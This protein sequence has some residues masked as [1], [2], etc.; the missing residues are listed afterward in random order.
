[1]STA[2][3]SGATNAFN[4]L[5][6]SSQSASAAVKQQMANNVSNGVSAGTTASGLAGNF[7]TFL[8]ILT[9]QLQHQDPTAP[10]DTNQFTQEL[11]QFSGV[12]Q[13]LNT[14]NLLQ[15]LVDANGASGVKS[16]L[17]YVGQYVQ[18]SASNQILVQNG[19]SEFSYTLP[20]VAQ[21]VLL[22]V[23]NA[24]GA[25]VANFSGPAANGTDYVAW[26]GQDNNGDQL[27]DGIYTIAV[28]ATDSGGNN[29]TAGNVQ[30]IGQ[31]TGV[32]TADS[33]GNDLMLGPNLTINDANVSAVFS[34]SA[35][36][37]ATTPSS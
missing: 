29:I 6:T 17:G 32:Q 8:K 35:I 16:L 31:V 21:N 4:S 24:A 27:P 20:S 5:V 28:A 1:M 15:K 10:L 23:K 19:Q 11:V 22:T 14:N 34:A 30:L 25:T 12:E 13:Q 18:V 36:P 2:P 9:T 26:N 33:S 37:K 7:N 3:I